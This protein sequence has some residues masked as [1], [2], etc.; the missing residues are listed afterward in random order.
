MV[1]GGIVDSIRLFHLSGVIWQMLRCALERATW[2]SKKATLPGI[3][4]WTEPEIETLILRVREPPGILGHLVTSRMKCM[5]PLNV[6]I[7]LGK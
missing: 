7:L 3:G 1:G 2:G 4:S 6:K 5:W